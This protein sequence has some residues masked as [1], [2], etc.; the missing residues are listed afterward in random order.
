MRP[1]GLIAI[2]RRISY[3]EVKDF[4]HYYNYNIIYIYILC[5]YIF[6]QLIHVC[7]YT[8]T[9]SQIHVGCVSYSAVTLLQW[10]LIKLVFSAIS[11][12]PSH[13]PLHEG[14]E[15]RYCLHLIIQ[16]DPN[17]LICGIR[18]APWTIR[19]FTCA[20]TKAKIAG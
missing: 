8:F 2:A 4:Q 11:S 14:L 9:H 7:M 16:N 13:G 3:A 12:L 15:H 19:N 18:M 20:F 6:V 1:T 10:P 5:M 17:W